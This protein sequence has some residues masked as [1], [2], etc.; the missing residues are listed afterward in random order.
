[1]NNFV[2]KYK[3]NT[4]QNFYLDNDIKKTLMIFIN[5]QFKIL[6]KGPSYSGKSTLVDIILNEYYK[7][8]K[9]DILVIDNISDN[10]INHLKNEVKNFCKRPSISKKNKT[11]II[12][13]FDEYN[14]YSQHILRPYIDNYSDV[15]F[16]F[17]CTKIKRI[18]TSI[19][20]RLNIIELKMPT[21]DTLLSLYNTIVEQEN[22][23]ID[24]NAKKYI[25]LLSN[26]SITKLLNNLEKLQLFDRKVDVDVAFKLCSG[27]NNYVFEKFIDLCKDGSTENVFDY[28]KSIKLNYYPL[29]D[30]L[31]I[32]LFYIKKIST[33]D[34]DTKFNI[35][36][37]I[38]FYIMIFYDKQEDDI[39]YL[40]FSNEIVNLLSKNCID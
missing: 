38:S 8:D 35:I 32:F 5:N 33:I 6:L 17:T 7:N 10:G 25:I 18:I 19:K 23:K 14:D 21:Y 30:F 31:N 27:I 20:T 9:K 34:E 36:K 39:E 37:I 13:D 24:D 29:I 26:S 16:L 40:F 11:V 2:V 3:P 28:I 1:M 4:L 22:I 15:N 12:D